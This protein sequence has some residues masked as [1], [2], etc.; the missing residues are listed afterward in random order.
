MSFVYYIKIEIP[1]TEIQKPAVEVNV[2]ANV[3]KP[4]VV[5]SISLID[6]IQKSLS[7]T[8]SDILRIKEKDIR[9]DMDMSEYG[10]NSLTFTEFANR[11]NAAFKI[12]INPSIFFEHPTLKS[13]ANYLNEEHNATILN[14][15]KV[16]IEET[17]KLAE[18]KKSPFKREGIFICGFANGG[19]SG[20]N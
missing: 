6:R 7:Q 16:E 18:N 11:V 14:A 15:F 19:L 13:F 9:L 1:K 10:F 4:A 3:Y 12:D 8:V 17:E 5:E 2:Q 20:L